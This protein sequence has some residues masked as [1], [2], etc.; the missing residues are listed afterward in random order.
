[1][2]QLSFVLSALLRSVPDAT[3]NLATLRLSPV[4]LQFY[5][6]HN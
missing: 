1:M 3:I 2:L 4:E 6:K 5:Q